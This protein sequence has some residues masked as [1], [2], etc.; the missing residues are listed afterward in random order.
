M[1]CPGFP[2]IPGRC[3]GFTLTGPRTLVIE[4]LS[5]LEMPFDKL[6]AGS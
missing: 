6:S 5:V 1:V 4:T 2:R 3:G